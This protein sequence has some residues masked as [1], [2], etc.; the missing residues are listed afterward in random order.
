MRGGG[1][2]LGTHVGR[3]Q[4]S[5]GGTVTPETTGGGAAL[6]RFEEEETEKEED[7]G[8]GSSSTKQVKV[9]EKQ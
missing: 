2:V 7:L 9:C 4:V 1:C 3:E 6:H 5:A 8:R